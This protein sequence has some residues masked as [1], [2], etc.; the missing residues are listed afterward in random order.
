[1][2]PNLSFMSTSAFSSMYKIT[3]DNLG[4]PG[5]VSTLRNRKTIVERVVTRAIKIDRAGSALTTG[6][7]NLRHLPST[8]K[9]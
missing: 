9:R 7:S 8:L 4:T 3:W 2:E 1:M 5:T 6:G